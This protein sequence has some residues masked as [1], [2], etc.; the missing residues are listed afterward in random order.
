MMLQVKQDVALSQGGPR[1]VLYISKS[2]K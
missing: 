2:R 1:D